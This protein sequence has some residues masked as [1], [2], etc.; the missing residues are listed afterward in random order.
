MKGS[1]IIFSAPSVSGK[2]T[3]IGHLLKSAPDVQFSVS[4][5]TRQPRGDETNGKEYFFMGVDEFKNGVN[6]GQFLEWQEVYPNQ[7]YGV[8]GFYLYSHTHFGYI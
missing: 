4:A 6:S 1:L 2:S 8:L 3:L 7:F 5:T